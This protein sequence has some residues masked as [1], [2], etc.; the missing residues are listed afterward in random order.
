[1]PPTATVNDAAVSDRLR[2]APR[3]LRAVVDRLLA[4]LERRHGENIDLGADFY[5]HLDLS[6]SYDFTTV[7]RDVDVGSLADDLK[8]LIAIA[9][10]PDGEPMSLP[11][12]LEHLIGILRR[13]AYLELEASSHPQPTPT[14]WIFHG[15]HARFASGVFPSAAAALEWVAQHHLTG[16]VT[17]YPVGVGA[18]DAA[19][20]EGRFRASRARH[21]TPDHIAG[22][23]PGL[24]HIHVS[25]GRR[26]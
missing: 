17:E 26:A 11:H 1:V 15:E 9:E 19:V 13:I 24:G 3:D 2:V 5:W 14:V 18:Y 7:E 16:I 21:G 8:S 6:N 23:S 4:A 22:F 25:D 12:E 10:R 20:R